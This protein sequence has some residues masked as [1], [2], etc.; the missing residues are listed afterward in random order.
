LISPAYAEDDFVAKLPENILLVTCA[1]DT[2]ALET[3]SLAAKI[4]KHGNK[5]LVR[6]C[7]RGV[8]HAWDKTAKPGTD[9]ERKRDEIYGLCI[10]MLKR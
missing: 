9:G 4:E 7:V 8:S 2:L 10:E 6:K 3:E 1:C 5:Y